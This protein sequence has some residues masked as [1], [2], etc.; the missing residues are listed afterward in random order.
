MDSNL[1][2]SVSITS[3]TELYASNIANNPASGIGTPAPFM[4]A[5]SSSSSIVANTSFAKSIRGTESG[6]VLDAPDISSF[7]YLSATSS[8]QTTVLDFPSSERDPSF[9]FNSTA[10]SKNASDLYSS[11]PS[12]NVSG[13]VTVS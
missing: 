8:A 5:S 6:S 12:I 4:V 11:T 10:L 3:S 7:S 1:T 13:S 2:V 9:P